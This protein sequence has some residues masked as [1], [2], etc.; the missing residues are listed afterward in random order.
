MNRE[1]LVQGRHLSGADLAFIS[2]WLEAHPSGNRTE[3]SRELCQMWNWRNGAGRL[4]DM[5]GRSLLLKLEAR[6][7]IR[8]PPRRTASVN[9]LRNRRPR[10]LLCESNPVC[11]SLRQVGPLP[12]EL[13]ESAQAKAGRIIGE[14][15]GA[16]V[17]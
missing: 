13:V 1:W 6:G 5:A 8:L 11:G 15:L 16:W 12:V 10:P 7:L 2:Q 9:G 14:E 4:K 17:G 3:L